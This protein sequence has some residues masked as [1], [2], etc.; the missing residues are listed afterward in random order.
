VISHRGKHSSIAGVLVCFFEPTEVEKAERQTFQMPLLKTPYDNPSLFIATLGSAEP[1][2][3]R[4]HFAMAVQT[5]IPA[6]RMA[7]SVQ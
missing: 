1:D 3:S 2:L 5:A 7:A 4:I 6:M